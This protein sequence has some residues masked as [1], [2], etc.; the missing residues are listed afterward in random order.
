[1]VATFSRPTDRGWREFCHFA[2]HLP[3]WRAQQQKTNTTFGLVSTQVDNWRQ[4]IAEMG[5]RRRNTRQPQD[6]KELKEEGVK[7]DCKIC[8]APQ[9]EQART[10]VDTDLGDVVSVGWLVVGI[11]RQGRKECVGGEAAWLVCGLGGERHREKK[12]EGV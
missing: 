7:D 4:P 10:L 1:M 6:A 2:F 11:E 12:L 8:G 3:H 5:T 9:A